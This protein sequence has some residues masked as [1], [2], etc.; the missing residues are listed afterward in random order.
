VMTFE[1]IVEAERK[2]RQ[3]RIRIQILEK[4]GWVT[5]H[6]RS[7]KNCLRLRIV[8]VRITGKNKSST[9]RRTQE[10]LMG[11]HRLKFESFGERT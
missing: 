9:T 6:V 3:G 1:K 5:D 7:D 2:A 8:C 10:H 11:Y 4:A